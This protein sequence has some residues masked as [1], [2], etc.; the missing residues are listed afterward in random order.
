MVHGMRMR[1][2]GYKLPWEVSQSI[3]EKKRK[4]CYEDSEA[5]QQVAWWGCKAS[6]LGGLQTQSDKA[7]SN[8]VWIQCWHCFQPK[9]GL[10][11]SWGP[12]Q[13]EG[14]RDSMSPA[15]GS[16]TRNN[17]K[18]LTKLKTACIWEPES[19]VCTLECKRQHTVSLCSRWERFVARK[20]C[21]CQTLSCLQELR[22]ASKCAQVK[23]TLIKE[24]L[25]NADSKA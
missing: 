9:V 24:E 4:V 22:F 5:V 10:E 18:G 23:S 15:T 11:T 2:N 12:L 20:Q 6:I 14:L 3:R 17:G 8:L 16:V 21:F 13:P 7:L 1:D 25:R 19:S